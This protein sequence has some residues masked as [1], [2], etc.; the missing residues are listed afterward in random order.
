M[1]NHSVIIL[2]DVICQSLLVFIKK[3][4]QPVLNMKQNNYSFFYRLIFICTNRTKMA[5]PVLKC[6]YL[7]QLTLQQVR[8]SAPHILTAGAESC[9]IFGQFARKISTLGVHNTVSVNT[10]SSS[11]LMFDKIKAIHEKLDEQKTSNKVKLPTASN[12][13]GESKNIAFLFSLIKF[14]F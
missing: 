1:H 11:P 13:Y 8:A 2:L 7:A 6:P 4:V 10:S 14:S 9:P 3:L 12:L 5:M